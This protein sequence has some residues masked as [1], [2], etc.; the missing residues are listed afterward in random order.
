MNIIFTD[1]KLSELSLLPILN[2]FEVGLAL[3][4]D[5]DGLD[6]IWS[7]YR[8]YVVRQRT[9]MFDLWL[10]NGDVTAEVIVKALVDTSNIEAALKLYDIKSKTTSYYNVTADSQEL[11]SHIRLIKIAHYYYDFPT[12]T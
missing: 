7:D 1:Y 2:W 6:V 5:K 9:E 8:D 12:S 4:L 10:H 11:S 3:G